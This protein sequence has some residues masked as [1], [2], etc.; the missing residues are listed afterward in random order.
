M[1]RNGSDIAAQVVGYAN[2]EPGSD[3]AYELSAP[4]AEIPIPW[5]T[6][7]EYTLE[8]PVRCPHCREP[9][10]TMRV[11]GLT[12]TRA[13]FTSTM[14]RKGRVLVCPECERIVSAEL[15]GLV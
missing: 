12:R 13:T 6:Q 5:Q 4:A 2:S 15:T 11:V 7:A 3:E 14:P 8:L 10:R 9:I 1:S